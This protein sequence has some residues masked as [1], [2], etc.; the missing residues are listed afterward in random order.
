MLW[1]LRAVGC[2]VGQ[3]GG[4][5]Q[6]HTDGCHGAATAAAATGDVAWQCLVTETATAS[7]QQT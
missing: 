5:Q 7:K 6:V 3:H 2:V 4:G 1:L